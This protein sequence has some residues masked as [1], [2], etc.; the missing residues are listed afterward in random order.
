MIVDVSSSYS[1]DLNHPM[2]AAMRACQVV[3]LFILELTSDSIN[4]I[5][6]FHVQHI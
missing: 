6:L 3:I 2:A 1:I 4:Q 5:L